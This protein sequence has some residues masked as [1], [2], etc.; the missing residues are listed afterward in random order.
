MIHFS[1]DCLSIQPH[2]HTAEWAMAPDHINLLGAADCSTGLKNSKLHADS[3]PDMSRQARL[4]AATATV[5][6][7]LGFYYSEK[8]HMWWNLCL[9]TW[10]LYH[11]SISTTSV[12][13]LYPRKS[14]WT[15]PR[16]SLDVSRSRGPDLDSNTL[17]KSQ[18]SGDNL[19]CC[20]VLYCIG[21]VTAED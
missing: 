21:W 5:N 7:L 20:F 9:R 12:W 13:Q 15:V 10:W 11:G 2:T 16:K 18:D 1:C 6:I 14:S 17:A 4:F 8:K 19:V 3:Y